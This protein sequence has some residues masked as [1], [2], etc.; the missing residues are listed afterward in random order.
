M[1]ISQI[2][3][4]E[5][6]FELVITDDSKDNIK[7][8]EIK[9]KTLQ[10]KFSELLQSSTS[11]SSKS[12]KILQETDV[13]IS[14]NKQLIDDE[15]KNNNKLKDLLNNLMLQHSKMIDSKNDLENQLKTCDYL[16]MELNN[17][18]Q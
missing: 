4:N 11:G 17:N 15:K 8:L 2:I 14:M 10:D 1:K 7:K 13:E 6:E 12:L 3:K 18:Q 16:V 5:D 9:N